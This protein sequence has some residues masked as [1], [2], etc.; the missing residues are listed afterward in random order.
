M[1]LGFFLRVLPVYFINID[2]P[3]T[4]II[5]KTEACISVSSFSFIKAMVIDAL[6]LSK[7]V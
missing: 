4:N 3:E 6:K 1:H 5:Y 2:T 7:Y